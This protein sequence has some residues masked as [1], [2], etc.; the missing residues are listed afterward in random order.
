[1]A[2]AVGAAPAIGHTTGPGGVQLSLLLFGGP[3]LYLVA[4]AW[5]YYVTTGRAWA[6]RLLACGACAVAGLAALRLPPLLSVLILDVILV[7]LVVA[8]TRV[9]RQVAETLNPD[10]GD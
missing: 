2:L 7:A 8:L 10:D 4:Q 1:M 9:H 5:W 3:I 6:A